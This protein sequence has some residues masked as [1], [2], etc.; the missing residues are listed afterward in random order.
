MAHAFHHLYAHVVFST[1]HR[2]PYLTESV[3]SH[4]QQ[5]LRE[6]MSEVFVYPIAVDGLPDHVHILIKYKCS[7]SVSDVVKHIKGKSAFLLNKH[8]PVPVSFKWSKGYFAASVSPGDVQRITSYILDQK[9]TARAEYEEW[10]ARHF[11]PPNDG[12]V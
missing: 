6:S 7:A 12:S 3:H 5:Y 8:A 10:V 9:K 11:G 2:Y 1:A 4:C